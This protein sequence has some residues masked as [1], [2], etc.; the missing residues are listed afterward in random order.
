MAHDIKKL[1]PRIVA[2]DRKLMGLESIHGLLGP[3]IH[4]PGW[5]TVAEY[6]LVNVALDAME[7]HADSLSALLTQL[8]SAANQVDPG[9]TGTKGGGLPGSGGTTRP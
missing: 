6:S 3:I 5:T 9:P 1:E 7:R 8:V 4:R 2:V